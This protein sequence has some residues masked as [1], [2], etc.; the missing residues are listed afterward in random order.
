MGTNE[1]CSAGMPCSAM[2]WAVQPS[3]RCTE[4]TGRGWLIRKISL[5][6]T[7]KTWAFTSCAWSESR[8]TASGAILLGVICW[9]LATRACC[10]GVSVGMEPIMRLQAKGAM[11]FERT[12]N[13][14]MSR[15]MDL[16]SATSASLAAL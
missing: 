11:Q 15:A 2:P 12:L 3:L 7:A 14:C 6:R 13:F 5:L 16:D 9:I 8:Y 1:R 4:R 10:S